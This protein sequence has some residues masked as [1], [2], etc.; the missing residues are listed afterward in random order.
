MWT[1]GGNGEGHQTN[2]REFEGTAEG[3][4]RRDLISQVESCMVIPPFF[5]G[6]SDTTLTLDDL[7]A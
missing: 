1:K 3:G 5:G 2:S 6:A 4:G 7:V